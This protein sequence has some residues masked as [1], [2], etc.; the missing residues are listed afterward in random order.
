MT[1][2]KELKRRYPRRLAAVSRILYDFDP[3][4]MGR[5]ADAPL[6][7]YDGQAVALLRG[8]WAAR[9]ASDAS[10]LIRRSYPEAE[11]D[12]LDAFWAARHEIG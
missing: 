7:E 10:Q 2:N 3:E 9:T 11:Q 12:L 1:S 5:S 8:L 6:D 4:G